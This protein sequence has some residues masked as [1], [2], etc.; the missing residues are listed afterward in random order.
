MATEK[1]T[2][3]RLLPIDDGTGERSPLAR[4]DFSHHKSS[5]SGLIWFDL[6]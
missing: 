1:V 2:C 6:L 3:F 4:L 5:Q